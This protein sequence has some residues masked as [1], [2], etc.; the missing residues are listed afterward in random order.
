MISR[1]LYAGQHA[2]RYIKE[3]PQLLFILIL[4]FII[5]LLFLYSGQQFLDV[6]RQNQDRLQKDRIG[7]MQDTF[8][9][10][11]FS[12]DFNGEII[13]R[14]IVRIAE[15][16]PDISD[17]KVIQLDGR[18]MKP[19]AALNAQQIGVPEEY[20][21]LYRNAVVRLDESLI[22][23]VFTNEGRVWLT[24]RAMQADTGVFYFI[25]TQVSLQAIDNSFKAGERD[26]LYSLIFVY[27]FILALAYWH[28]RLT[29]YR[30]LYIKVRKANE[31]KDLFTNMIAHELRAPLTA[32]RGYSSMIIES[33]TDA[34]QLKN[35]TRVKDSS[36]RLLAIVNDLLDVA[37]IQSGKLSV[38][39]ASFDASEIVMSV[40]DELR[41]SATEKNIVLAHIGTIENHIVMG[42]RKRLHQAIT[43]LVSNAIK[44]TKDGTIELT[45]EEK[46]NTVEIRVKDTGMGISSEDQKKLFA[47]FF[48][49]Q[50]DD[51]SQITGTGLGMWI[52]KQL[53]ELM[54]A[55]IG[56]ESI[57]GVGTH[58]VIKLPKQVKDHGAWGTKS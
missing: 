23:E 15:S 45:L 6:G 40:T 34:E 43:N 11:L 21:E 27:V 13:Q 3:H 38:D 16:N 55:K 28:I 50:N 44:Y 30:Y 49:V 22:F 39:L 5:P 46:Y 4:I 29:D 58:V 17:F 33:A 31:M 1:I 57:K 24:Y 7:L 37:R 25:Y 47:P 56:V 2:L 9:S 32:I 26:A 48:R 36:E 19:I 42:D 54:G 52:T 14:E 12:S 8:A 18:E 53:I 20:D 41:V 51:V 10:I 35:A